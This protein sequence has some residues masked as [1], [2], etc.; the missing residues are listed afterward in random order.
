MLV[1]NTL[2]YYFMESRKDTGIYYCIGPR[3]LQ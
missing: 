3:Y 1:L 2:S